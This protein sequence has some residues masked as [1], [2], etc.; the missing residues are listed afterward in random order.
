MNREEK[1]KTENSITVQNIDKRPRL[2]PLADNTEQKTQMQRKIQ[3][4]LMATVIISYLRMNREEQREISNSKTNA[5]Y[6]ID[7]HG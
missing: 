3:R 6:L 5:T 2:G 1:R 7:T 4:R